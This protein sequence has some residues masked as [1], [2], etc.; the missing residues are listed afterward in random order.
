M[1][2]EIPFRII[3]PTLGQATNSEHFPHPYRHH[4]SST[5]SALELNIERLRYIAALT[6][7]QASSVSTSTILT[8]TISTGF[9]TL[10]DL[11]CGAGLPCAYVYAAHLG[12]WS[13][14]RLAP[15]GGNH[16]RVSRAPEY[17][18]RLPTTRT[19]GIFA[20]LDSKCSADKRKELTSLHSLHPR[21]ITPE[22]IEDMPSQIFP[23]EQTHYQQKPTL[24]HFIAPELLA[25]SSLESPRI[26]YATRLLQ[27]ALPILTPTVISHDV[28][29]PDLVDAI[30]RH[31]CHYGN[32]LKSYA[33]YGDLTRHI[34]TI[35][36]APSSYFCHFDQ[37]P[38]SINGQ[39]FTR[40]D[41]LIAHL[42]SR[43]HRVSAEDAAYVAALHNP[44]R[45]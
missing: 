37:R 12:R 44:P 39:G 16:F 4:P 26:G 25:K 30:Q 20:L 18:V 6:K 42:K 35:H 38:R 31:F 41:K 40:K 9:A 23:T 21:P 36:E 28:D 24:L 33:R 43:K 13:A 2:L 27:K 7:M 11:Y 34:K 17:E 5:L 45:R 19:F 8:R 1:R 22:T 3:V 10:S 29:K 14:C 15:M 32:C